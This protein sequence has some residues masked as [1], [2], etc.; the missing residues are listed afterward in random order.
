MGIKNLLL[1][2]LSVGSAFG[3]DELHT[4]LRE[5][6]HHIHRDEVVLGLQSL[7]NNNE[8]VCVNGRYSLPSSTTE[9]EFTLNVQPDCR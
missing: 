8:V 4:I 3:V 5:E 6:S 7:Y 9:T 2:E 1:K